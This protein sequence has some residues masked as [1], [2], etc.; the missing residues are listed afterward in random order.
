[1]PASKSKNSIR[2]LALALMTRPRLERDDVE[3]LLRRVMDHGRL[4]SRERGHIRSL[5]D[6][7]EG[8]SDS[9]EGVMRLRALLDIRNDAL[10]EPRT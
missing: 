6:R 1:M 5:V 10:R 4:T 2:D 9:S 7:F 8:Q 3:A